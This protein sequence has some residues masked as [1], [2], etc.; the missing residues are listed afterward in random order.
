MTAAMTPRSHPL[1]AALALATSA[2]CLGPI[3]AADP[4]QRA[5]NRPDEAVLSV[6]GVTFLIRPGEGRGW[7]G[8]VQGM[9]AVELTV[10][11]TTAGAVRIQ[12]GLF[13]LA[14]PGGTRIPALEPGVVVMRVRSS[15]VGPPRPFQAPRGVIASGSG[16][17]RAGSA[18]ELLYAWPGLRGIGPAVLDGI[19][20]P[21]PR[22]RPEGD[23]E[24]GQVASAVLFFPVPPD[25]GGDF[26]I[27]VALVGEDGKVLASGRAPFTRS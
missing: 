5:P 11:N 4:A 12:P 3:R 21:D 1:I 27:E 24:A 15:I 9:T 8:E 16:A 10:R 26:A 22:P 2:G 18:I 25:R 19:I 7:L 6:G 13:T 23:V 20:G 14:L 17:P